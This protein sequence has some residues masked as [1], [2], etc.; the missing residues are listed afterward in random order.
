MYFS[1]DPTHRLRYF[2]KCYN[3]QHISNIHQFPNEFKQTFCTNE[4]ISNDN[5]NDNDNN[6]IN[7]SKF[8]KRQ[9]LLKAVVNKCVFNF[10]SKVLH[11]ISTFKLKQRNET[12]GFL[13]TPIL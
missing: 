8:M 10:D 1:S 7:Y 9:N 12:K 3:M 5:S 4:T 13:T 6:D 11:K 2:S